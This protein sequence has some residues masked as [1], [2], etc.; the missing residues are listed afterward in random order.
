MFFSETNVPIGVPLLSA[1]MCKQS[2][3]TYGAQ[4]VVFVR[5]HNVYNGNC[6]SCTKKDV[7]GEKGMQVVD[8]KL[9]FTKQRANNI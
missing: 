1:I 8:E 5:M 4:H 7:G 6:G 3:V 2:N 9:N